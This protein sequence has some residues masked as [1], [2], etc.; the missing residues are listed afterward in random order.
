M[1]IMC[2]VKCDDIAMNMKRPC[3]NS[4]VLVSVLYALKR[5]SVLG[6]IGTWLASICCVALGQV[7]GAPIMISSLA[8][9]DQLTILDERLVAAVHIE[10]T[11]WWSSKTEGRVILNDETA[12]L[13]LELDLPCQMPALGDRLILEGECTATKTRDVIKLS[14]VPVVDHDGLHPPE[15]KSGTVYLKAGHHPIRVA[16]FDRTDRYDLKVS[17]EG[18]DLPRQPVPD[19]VLFRPEVDEG[20]GRTNFV[21]GLDYKCY[22]GAWWRLLPNF[23]HIAAVKTGV[24]DNFDIAV[25]SRTSHVGLQF[26]GYIKVPRDGEYTFYVWSDDG[27]RLFIGEP[28]LRV[29]TRGRSALPSPSPS[30]LGEVAQEEPELQWSAIEG[31]VT[32]FHHLQGT[33]EVDLMTEEGLVR[34]RVAEDSD[35]SYTLRPDNRLRAVGVSRKIF[36]LGGRYTRSEF[37]AQHWDDIEQQYITPTIWTEYPLAK[38]GSLLAMEA[39]NIVDSAVHLNGQITSMGAGQPMMLDDGTG[40]IILDG[41]MPDDLVGRSSDVLGLLSFKGSNWVLRCVFIH[42]MGDRGAETS[43]L[44]VLTTALQVSQLSLSDAEQGYPVRLKG[45]ITSANEHDGAVL[46]DSSQGIYLWLTKPPDVHP[47]DWNPIAVQIG[48]YCEIEGVT[49]PYLFNPYIQVSRLEK[50]GTGALPEPVRPSWDQLI[51]GSMH[52]KYVEIEGVVTLIKD[53]TVDLMTRNGH[54]NIQLNPIGP[55]MPADSLGA[56]IRL[57]G[58]LL[59]DWDGDFRRVVV[60]SIYLD[61]NRVTIVH[62]APVDPFAIPLKNVAD[63]LQFDPLG[64]ALQRVKVSGVLLHK[65]EQM[66]YLMDGVNGLRFMPLGENAA[67]IGDRVEVVG[68]LDISGPSPLLSDAIVRQFGSAEPPVPRKLNQNE[69]LNDAFDATLV[70]LEGVLLS[71]SPRQDGSVLEIQTGLRRFMAMLDYTPNA[72]ELPAP[73]SYLE[74]TGIFVGQGGNRVLG[75]PIDSFQLHLNSLGDINVLSRPSWWTFKRLMLVVF[76]L[77]AVLLAALIWIELLHRKVEDRT[78]QLGDQIRQRQRAEHQREIE[79]ERARLAH[80]LHDD[81]GAGLTEVNMLSSLVKN[82]STSAAEKEQYADQMSELALRMVTSLD[83]IV[84]AE[85][86]TNDTVA[87]LA[88]YFGAYAKRFMDL[89]SVGCGL[90]VEEDLP[91]FPIDPSFRR[92]LFLA[93]KEALTNVIKHAGAAKVWLR[94]GIQDDNVEVTVSDDG[95]GVLPDECEPGANGLA[96][97]RKRLAALGG[98]CEILSDPEKGTTVCLKAPIREVGT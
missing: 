80:D 8:E 22:E 89:A 18:P 45:V 54:I 2:S 32:S 4:G 67:R 13:Q 39:T 66:S 75:Q 77:V 51:N 30:L 50:L 90:D 46:Q 28:S 19:E 24:V 52:C 42:R 29:R 16:W 85:N 70:Q 91:D 40:R 37:Y 74:L 38:I 1:V 17:Y 96:G 55:P 65:D 69:L 93:F 56:T 44:P 95:C 97:M 58:C 87:S 49:V 23:D 83:E 63:L 98:H 47:D 64:G 79:H 92:E 78:Q 35:G 86:P 48:D 71:V 6:A 60:G 27:S 33:L 14:G 61:Q 11:V 7:D 82:P 84:W 25:R 68:Y 72:D 43:S 5:L 94:I 12:T 76:V 53:D 81:L 88:G 59:A 41:S 3:S 15:E 26:V 36:D 9:L 10:G 31:V 62:P 34:L 57:R 20:T 21:N 73:G